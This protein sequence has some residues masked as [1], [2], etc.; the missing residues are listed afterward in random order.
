MSAVPA[1]R[2]VVGLPSWRRQASILGDRY[3]D[4]MLGDLTTLLL[5]IAQAPVIGA[6]CVLVWGGIER[7]TDS[8]YFVL[9]LTS[10][11]F[12]CIN[13]CREIVKERSILERERLFGLSTAAYVMSKAQVLF[14]IDLIQV[15]L[16]LGVVESRI[17][18]RGNLL[19]QALALA[20]CAA[21]GTGLGL[22]VSALSRRQEFAVAAVPLLILPQILFSEFAL[23]RENFSTAVEWIERFM[24]VKWGYRVFT[25][26]VKSEVGYGWIAL[27]LGVL[28]VMT[29]AL[30][31][32]SVLVLRASSSED[33]L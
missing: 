24:P 19:W 17:G 29:L 15:A 27:S 12:G 25:E 14:V 5:L 1:P 32:A 28:V 18:L 31:L 9:A 7:D 3:I 10:V 21:A 11:W 6:L 30:H 8:L 22:L 2:S 26:A 16:L 4:L 33:F 20:G 23:P 13:A